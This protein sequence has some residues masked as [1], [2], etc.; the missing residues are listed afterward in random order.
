MPLEFSFG[1]YGCALSTQ[2]I[3]CAAY[4]V[5]TLRPCGKA[6]KATLCQSLDTAQAPAIASYTQEAE[7]TNLTPNAAVPSL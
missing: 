2:N 3:P 4:K 1:I 7:N 5:P 6:G